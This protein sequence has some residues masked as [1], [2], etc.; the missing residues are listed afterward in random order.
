[1]RTLLYNEECETLTSST[2]LKFLKR[3][4]FDTLWYELDEGTDYYLD[5]S[6]TD[7]KKIDNCVTRSAEKRDGRNKQDIYEGICS[8]SNC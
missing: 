2:A 8:Q 5:Y 3:E 4:E 1:M 7:F 6:L